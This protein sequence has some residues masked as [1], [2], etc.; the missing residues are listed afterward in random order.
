M[1]PAGISKGPV[2]ADS[3]R[4]AQQAF[5]YRAGTVYPY[6]RPGVAPRRPSHRGPEECPPQSCPLARPARLDRVT[7]AWPGRPLRPHGGQRTAEAAWAT[8]GA[9]ASCIASPPPTHSPAQPRCPL[10]VCAYK[11]SGARRS[12][13]LSEP[14]EEAGAFQNRIL[15]PLLSTPNPG[16]GPAEENT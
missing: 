9:P 8:Q 3:G 4:R 7:A 1:E 11:L 10:G 2:P 6:S 16:G 13:Q 14:A 5:P 12:W 15:N